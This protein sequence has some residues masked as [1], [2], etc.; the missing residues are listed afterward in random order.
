M[1]EA[2]R[3]PISPDAR[4][5]TRRTLDE[6][7]FV[8]W[9]GA[10]AP[11][12]RAVNRL[13]P[14]SRLRRALLR[15]DVRAAVAAW[16]RKDLEAVVA[17]VH[18]QIVY[19]PRADEPDPSPHVGRDAYEQLVYGF[20]DSFSRVTFEVLEVI[21]AGDHVITS[22]VLHAVLRGQESAS[23]AGVSDTYVFVYK[24]RDG[25]VVECWEYRTK[26]EALEAVGLSEPVA[27]AD[28]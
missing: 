12:A 11:L 25:L 4:L 3:I 27:Y 19:H 7:L 1:A 8:R 24:L 10:F 2:V 26:Q 28:S 23:G 5:P 13:P 22:T 21:D 18:P 6:R 15:R 17:R 9:P 14:R 20:V 16:N